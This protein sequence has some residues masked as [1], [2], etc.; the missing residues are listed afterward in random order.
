MPVARLAPC[1]IGLNQAFH[2]FDLSKLCGDDHRRHPLLARI[3]DD[4]SIKTP[5][6]QA[7]RLSLRNSVSLTGAFGVYTISF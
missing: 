6:E 5:R 3:G 7:S 2:F 1:A 4:L